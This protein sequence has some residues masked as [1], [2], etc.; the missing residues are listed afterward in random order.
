[1]GKNKSDEVIINENEEVVVERV[2][3]AKENKKSS[4]S[5]KIKNNKI[6]FII[7]IIVI[8]LLGIIIAIVNSF[9]NDNIKKVSK[10]LPNKYYN[11]VCLDKT[12]D[13]IAAYKGS[14][15]G[16]SKVTLLTGNGK[17][18]ASYK[19]NYDAKAKTIKEPYA[20]TENYFIYK[21]TN[22][23]SKKIVGYSIADKRG[24]EKY[25]TDKS[26]KV[27]TKDLVLLDDTDKG[28]NGYSILNG[29]GKLLFKNV[30][31]FNLYADGRIISAEIDGTKQIINEKGEIVLSD[32][33][34]A[35]EI[36]D[37]NYEV[38]KIY[39]K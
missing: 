38:Y 11:I 15:T 24:K 9:K 35:T 30:N 31:D 7:L 20:L 21:K 19:N 34:V 23:N 6:L 1:M 5:S 37:E 8:L 25:S 17:V 29:K 33:Y 26:L 36:Y 2:E 22:T 28:I 3:T 12:C 14:A 10:I 32:Y 16:K 13:Q 27:L 39:L 18:V 4:V